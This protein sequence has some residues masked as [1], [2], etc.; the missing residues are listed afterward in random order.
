MIQKGEFMDRMIEFEGIDISIPQKKNNVQPMEVVE[1]DE[2]KMND[3][4]RRYMNNPEEYQK[5]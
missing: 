5:S 4:D 1:E 3:A 2:A